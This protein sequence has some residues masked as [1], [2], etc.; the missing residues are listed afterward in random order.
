MT[1]TT[2]VPPLCGRV[3]VRCEYLVPRGFRLVLTAPDVEPVVFHDRAEVAVALHLAGYPLTRDL[4][5]GQVA[6]LALHGAIRAGIGQV[7]QYAQQW[8]Q[9]NG[10]LLDGQIT[11][12]A[13]R[14]WCKEFWSSLRQDQLCTDLSWRLHDTDTARERC[15]R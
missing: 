15:E 7:R 12:R 4:T 13:H 5:A 2:L 9:V 14:L 3:S 10:Q 11:P 1:T 8:R 6:V